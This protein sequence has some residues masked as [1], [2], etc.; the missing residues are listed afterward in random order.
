MREIKT[1]HGVY[2][3][4]KDYCDLFAELLNSKAL[5]RLK[6]IDQSGPVTYFDLA[7]KYTRY[8]HSLGVLGLIIKA[9]RSIKEQVAALLHDVSHTAFSHLGDLVFADLIKNN[10]GCDKSY[11]DS[12]HLE[13]LKNSDIYS[14][15]KKYGFSIE[16]LN[17]HLTSYTALERELPHMCADR[18]EYVL[19]TGLLLNYI[20]KEELKHIV[21]NLRFENE[22][23][24]FT[25]LKYAKQF[26]NL[27][28]LINNDF[29]NTEHNNSIYYYFHEMIKYA[30]SIGLL[31][32]NDVKYG[33]DCDILTKLNIADN[34]KIQN[35]M[36][37]C[38]NI[39]NTI[40]IEN[41]NEKIQIKNK[42][43]GI[44]PLVC[45][46]YNQNQFY[47]LSQIDHN[48]KTSFQNSKDF[49]ISPM[50]KKS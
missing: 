33:T 32:V 44:D 4:Q 9:K 40:S 39:K 20:S 30:I 23:W 25:D 28:L 41:D 5:L 49:I 19:H 29:W 27:V 11:Q 37:L 26:A 38:R 31:N 46:N 13:F 34:Q 17:P 24:F 50:H 48:F 2:K 1:V 15:I 12:I 7:P 14:I 45:V 35:Y 47:Q 36:K 43:R 21:N 3:I 22:L 16:D 10:E 8:D 18:I 42:F 6:K